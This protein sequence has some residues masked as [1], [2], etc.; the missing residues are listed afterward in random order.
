MKERIL[1]ILKDKERSIHELQHVLDLNNS[2]GFTVL[3]KALN[4]L[5]DE[6]KIVR[7]DKNEYLLIENSNYIVGVL[8]INKRG[9][10]FVIIDEESDDIFISS[11]DLKDAFNMDTVMVELKSIKQDRVK[12]VE[13][14]KLLKEDKQD[15]LG[16]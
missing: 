2:E 6:G 16:C 13:L 5:E 3:L 11:R 14:L 8:H 15:L 7:N 12:K 9:F 10:G 1:D 4:Q